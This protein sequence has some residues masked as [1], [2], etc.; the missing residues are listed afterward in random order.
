MNRHDIVFIGADDDPHFPHV[1]D[2]LDREPIIINLGSP[3]CRIAYEFVRGRVAPIITYKD[4]EIDPTRVL[5]VWY[6]NGVPRWLWRDLKVQ[7]EQTEYVLSSLQHQADAMVEYLSDGPFWVSD[8]HAVKRAQHKPR[9]LQ[10]ANMLR[11]RTP[12][13]I[14]ASDAKRAEAFVKRHG[15]VIVKAMAHCA[16]EGLDQYSTLR[17]ASEMN[18]RGLVANPH[19][20]QELIMPKVEV[21][22]SVIGNKVF[23]TKVG[24][25]DAAATLATGKRDYREAFNTGHFDVEPYDFPRDIAERFVALVRHYRTACGYADFILGH[26]D[27]WYFLENNPNGQWGFQD[28]ETIEGIAKAHAELLMTGQA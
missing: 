9:Q 11:L 5:S 4:Q 15:T 27:E 25:R 3:E 28:P 7:P 1:R 6:R 2:H 16:P 8:P 10:V 21:R 12:E 19:I 13:T 24:D 23:A 26:D 20:F 17:T 18:F 22:V 14:F